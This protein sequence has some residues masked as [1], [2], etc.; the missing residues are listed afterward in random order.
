LLA[1][2]IDMSL[3]ELR[4]VSKSQVHGSRRVEVLRDVS[5]EIDAGE[6]V[7]VWGL[8]RSGRSTLLAVAAGVDQPDAGEVLFDG[9]DM[10]GRGAA[11]LGNGVGFCR[12]GVG[13]PNGRTVIDN[14][15][16]GLLARGGVQV[17]DA[18]LRA[19]R[20]L[21]RVGV[22][23]CGELMLADLDGAEA[24]RVAIACA[25]VLGPRLLVI[26]EPSKGVD[27]LQ[28]DEIVL[29]LRSLADEGIAILV[30]DG[31]GSGLSDADRSLSLAGGE[32]RGKTSPEAGG[33]LLSLERARGRSSAA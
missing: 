14:V 24:V 19:H 23:E 8:R 22:E 3:L 25:L 13:G 21:E 16:A 2:G 30:S 33:A 10:N 11:A 17:P 32:L 31:D 29:L 6:F 1:A 15:R 12:Q 9:V 26:D 18:H 5:L 20:A 27:L 28:R 4:R 7:A